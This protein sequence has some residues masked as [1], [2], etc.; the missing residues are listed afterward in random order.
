ME[1]RY[2]LVSERAGRPSSKAEF[3]RSQMAL[4]RIA[5]VVPLVLAGLLIP[6]AGAAP[7]DPPAGTLG[8]GHEHFTQS[9][10]TLDC[11]Q[12]LQMQNDSRWVHIIG[13]GRNGLLET[14]ADVPIQQRKLLET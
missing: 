9:V 5:V 14:A 11:G 7:A 2:R 8:M 12:P 6:A 3:G 1:I 10:V 4:P 13:P